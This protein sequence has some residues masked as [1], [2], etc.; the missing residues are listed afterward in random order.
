MKKAVLTIVLLAAIAICNAQKTKIIN[1]TVEQL[2]NPTALSTTQPRFSWQ[3]QSKG[4]NVVQTTYRIIVASTYKN[5][6][7]GIGDLW[8]SKDVSS[9]QMLYIPYGGKQLK[10]RDKAYWTVQ[11]TV[12]CGEP[13]KQKTL[14][15][16]SDIQSFAISLTDTADWQARWIGRDFADDVLTGHTRIA[17][18]YLRKEFKTKG[19][20]AEARLYISGL[21]QYSAYINGTEVAPDEI[22][23]PALSDYRKRVYFNTYD[24]TKL[25]KRGGNAI[26]VMLEGGRFTA[27]RINPDN[28]NRD[29]V[30]NILH[31]GTPRLIAQLEI[32][33]TNGEKE[34]VTTDNSWRITNQGPIRTA[35]EFDGETYNA[36]MELTDW[37]FYGYDDHQWPVAEN[38]A[39]PAG[40]LDPQPNPN[41]KVQDRLKPIAIFQKDGKY[42]VDM[43][44]NMVGNLQLAMKNQAIGDTVTLRFAET[45]LPDS[46]LCM[47]TLR[48][49]EVTDR[50][51]SNGLPVIWHPT[52]VYHGFRY[53]EISG[54]RSAPTANDIT[55][56]VFYDEMSVTGNFETSNEIINAIYHNAYWGIRGNYR[57]MPTDCPQRDER[58]GWN[59]DRTTGCYGESFIFNNNHLYSKWITDADDSQL[60]TGSLPDVMPAYWRFYSN[61]MTWPGAIITSAD[62]VYT[63]FGND[64]PIRR[65][66]TA[67]KKWLLFMKEKYMQNGIMTKDTYGDW[68]L[69][70][71]SP[72][73]IHSKDSTRITAAPVISTPFYCYLCGKMVKFA[74]LLGFDTDT[75]YFQNEIATS[76]EAFNQKYFDTTKAQY[77]NGTVTANLMPLAF[78]MVPKGYEKAVFDNIVKK[79][80]IDFNGHVST[81]VIGIQQIM[82][83]LT[84]HGRID[85]AYKLATNTDYPSW[86]YMVRNGATTIWELWN[87][88]T[89]NPAMNSGN[90]VM[91]LGDLLIWKYEYLAGIRANAPG[92][93]DIVLKPHFVRGLNYVKCSYQS[94]SG[95]IESSWERKNND[96]YLWKFTI[97]ANTT[98]TVMVPDLDGNYHAEQRGSGTYSVTITRRKK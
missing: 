39:A 47:P 29:G 7:Q 85:L 3:Y 87:G 22:L 82:R 34:V 64:Q 5:A 28:P 23:K 41:I 65:H 14:S 75:T 12:T 66:Y 50:Y 73:L 38:V 19:G 57:S 67:M 13:D 96:R 42:I 78:G 27:M 60:E 25:L 18:R 10:S 9:A 16:T 45:L 95:V 51:I 79:T 21:G 86:G 33:Y 93:S 81:G 94:V 88:N 53:V 46:S 92:Y 54:L 52:F 2:S 80:E 70:P 30:K 71:E 20:V 37:T 84:D 89:A 83:T 43:G 35:N 72:E 62:M 59:G 36:R 74:R 55:G 91:L 24:V 40:K 44:Q 26:A 4:K 90:H 58:M 11:T 15:Q 98:A 31:F 56:L 61:S 76:T 49:A 69:P 48:A 68:C 8:D 1:P 17:A 6:K 77:D 32:T 97:P 63:R